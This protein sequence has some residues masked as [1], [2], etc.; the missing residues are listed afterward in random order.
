M[1]DSVWTCSL[2]FMLLSHWLLHVQ[3]LLL[4]CVLLVFII[5]TC[6]I[7]CSSR[8][9]TDK[10]TLL[11]ES[12]LIPESPAPASL[13]LQDC[14]P[15]CLVDAS[16]CEMTT[17]SL[18]CSHLFCSSCWMEYVSDKVTSGVATGQWPLLPSP[19][20]FPSPLSPS[21]F[22]LTPGS[23]GKSHGKRMILNVA[24]VIVVVFQIG[25]VHEVDLYSRD[26]SS[27]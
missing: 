20:S 6:Y 16:E 18:G 23:M 17:C 27:L 3:M 8:Y 22:P 9:S 7:S 2:V 26:L 12:H 19:P 24:R 14:C 13:I 25:H 11:K 1:S 21:L 10:L 15:V 4:A 5:N